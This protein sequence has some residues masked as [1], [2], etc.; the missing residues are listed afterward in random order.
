VGDIVTP[1]Q[2]LGKLIEEIP[3][4]PSADVPIPE[5]MVRVTD[6]QLR[7]HGVFYRQRRPII[8]LVN[9]ISPQV[10]IYGL[11]SSVKGRLLLD[12]VKGLR[13]RAVKPQ[14]R[15]EVHNSW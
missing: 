1:A 5:V 9:H 10:A 3:V 13:F 14:E 7:F 6:G 8:R 11:E 2:V 12:G 15:P 4:A